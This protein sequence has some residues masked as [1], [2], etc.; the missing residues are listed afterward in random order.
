MGP[1]IT[2]LMIGSMSL[3]QAGGYSWRNSKGVL[4]ICVAPM[5]EGGQTRNTAEGDAMDTSETLTGTRARA[6]ADVVGI[7]EESSG[8][9][10]SD[11]A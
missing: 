8:R 11:A 3:A 4:K 10:K 1:V 5:D 6:P 9:Q 2:C 7:S